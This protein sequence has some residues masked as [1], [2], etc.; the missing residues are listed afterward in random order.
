MHGRIN[1]VVVASCG[2]MPV[3]VSDMSEIAIVQANTDLSVALTAPGWAS[4]NNWRF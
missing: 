1:A 2:T 4:T 3:N